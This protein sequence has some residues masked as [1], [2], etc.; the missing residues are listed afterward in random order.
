M[1]KKAT[2]A[3]SGVIFYVKERTVVGAKR[4]SPKEVYKSFKPLADADQESF[5]IVCYNRINRELC[6]KCLFLGGVNEAT[7]DLKIVFKRILMSGASGWIAIH[8]HPTGSLYPSEED[9]FLTNSLREASKLLNLDFLD[10]IIIPEDG[11]F[12][13]MECELL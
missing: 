10:H 4:G 7:V 13:F 1:N 3:Q 12:S 11:Y 6:R 5:W 8:N 9:I 2:R